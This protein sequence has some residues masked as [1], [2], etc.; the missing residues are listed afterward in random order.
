MKITTTLQKIYDCEPCSSGWK[1]LL[2]HLGKT[3]ADDER[4]SMSLIL[5]SNDLDD[6]LWAL[7]S[8]PDLSKLWRLF[9]V[10][11]ARSVQHLMKDQRS[12]DALDVAERHANGEASDEERS[13]ARSAEWAAW[14]AESA[15]WA[16][17]WAAW[18]AESAAWAAEPA[19]RSAAA[20][21]AASAARSEQAKILKHL[22]DTGEFPK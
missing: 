7:R 14:A 3:K 2:K 11:C 15:A 9:A 4:F 18:A 17:E 8:R 6:C 5:E 10:K 20:S 13:A 22:L 21:A 19:A 12:I 1:K 16:A